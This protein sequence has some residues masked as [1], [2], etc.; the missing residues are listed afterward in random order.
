MVYQKIYFTIALM[1]EI[2]RTNNSRRNKNNIYYSTTRG[3][4]GGGG[5]S[6][7][8]IVHEQCFGEPIPLH[9][10]RLVSWIFVNRSAQLL[11]CLF[12][13]CGGLG[14]GWG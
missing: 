12:V 10:S 2:T 1:N 4:G 8:K 5:N 9:L 7:H 11:L 6:K 3:S 14:G 13:V